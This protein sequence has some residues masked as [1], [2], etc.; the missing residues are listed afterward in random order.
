MGPPVE[1]SCLHP[2]YT[3]TQVSVR[4]RVEE[5]VTGERGQRCSQLCLPLYPQRGEVE[6]VDVVVGEGRREQVRDVRLQLLHL[7]AQPALPSPMATISSVS[8][9]C[10]VGT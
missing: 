6:V 10:V 3:L 4:R 5:R 8:P 1:F 7:A 9:P 2:A